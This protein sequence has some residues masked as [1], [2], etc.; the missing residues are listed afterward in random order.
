MNEPE[1]LLLEED[2]RLNTPSPE[3]SLAELQEEDELGVAQPGSVVKTPV[4][5]V[6][7]RGAVAWRWPILAAR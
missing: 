1:E 4:E 6:S 2:E 3:M 7:V 5:D